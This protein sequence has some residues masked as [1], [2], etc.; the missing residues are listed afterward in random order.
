MTRAI[1]P[2]LFLLLLGSVHSA[3]ASTQPADTAALEFQGFRAGARLHEI[4]SL[5]RSSGGSRFVAIAPR[6]TG[7]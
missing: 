3:S 7:M 2:A 5:V 4:D 6:R 1:R